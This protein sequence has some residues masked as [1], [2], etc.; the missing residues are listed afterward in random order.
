M[1]TGNTNVLSTI[2]IEGDREFKTPS[3]TVER[4]TAD[5]QLPNKFLNI[6]TLFLVRHSS[7]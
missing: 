1:S 5:T 2:G 7:Y 4:T 6:S 3:D